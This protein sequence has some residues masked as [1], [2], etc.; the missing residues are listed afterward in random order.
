MNEAIDPA[1]GAWR[2][3][4]HSLPQGDC[5]EVALFTDGRV[6]LRDS[7]NPAGGAIVL[8][9]EEFRGLLADIKKGKI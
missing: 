4:R 7:K 5:V 2:K 1:W 3:S 9:A 8:A 6:G